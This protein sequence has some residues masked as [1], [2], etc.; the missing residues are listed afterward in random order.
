MSLSPMCFLSEIMIILKIMKL[1][2]L[3][4]HMINRILHSWSF[5][6]KFMKRGK[7]SFHLLMVISYEM[8]T[9]VRS[10]MFEILRVD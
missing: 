3:Q 8:I 2:F 5:H 1:L 7:G 6:L 4:G 10:F 9:H